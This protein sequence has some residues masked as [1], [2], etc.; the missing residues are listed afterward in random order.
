[1][2][3]DL[4][5]EIKY[6][7][8]LKKYEEYNDLIDFGVLTSKALKKNAKW[9]MKNIG[10]GATFRKNARL[11]EIENGKRIWWV[12]IVDND[13][14]EKVA[15]WIFDE[16]GNTLLCYPDPKEFKRIL[17]EIDRRHGLDE[18]GEPIKKQEKL[19]KAIG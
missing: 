13:F 17:I 14:E 1:M 5:S 10:A 16:E 19:V 15:D 11:V 8:A 7:K 3:E 4:L 9:Y 2:K 12:D 6:G 18:W